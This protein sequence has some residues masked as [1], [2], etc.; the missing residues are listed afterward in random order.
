MPTTAEK[1]NQPSAGANAA[2]APATTFKTI[3]AHYAPAHTSHEA[4][5]KKFEELA[6]RVQND[7]EAQRGH[8]VVLQP[9]TTLPGPEDVED[10]GDALTEW[11]TPTVRFPSVVPI[12]VFEWHTSQKV[13]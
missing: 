3:P 8:T 9:L 4:Y 5:L 11:P 10:A 7:L 1:E 12:S 2:V 13:F 6:K